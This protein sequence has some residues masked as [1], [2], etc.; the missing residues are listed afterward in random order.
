MIVLSQM[1]VTVS[2]VFG[3]KVNVRNASSFGVVISAGAGAGVFAVLAV[4]V[5]S[6][7][8]LG[9]GSSVPACRELLSLPSGPTC[10]THCG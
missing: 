10:Y 4:C 9:R 1:C 6:G 3:F 7:S 8:L 5:L 2:L